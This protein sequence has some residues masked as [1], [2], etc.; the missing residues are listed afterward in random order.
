MPDEQDLVG[1]RCACTR[2]LDTARHVPGPYA[3]APVAAERD[4]GRRG[5]QAARRAEP[6]VDADDRPADQDVRGDGQAVALAVPPRD[7]GVLEELALEAGHAERALDHPEGGR[8][9]VDEQRVD[10]RATRSHRS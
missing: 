4:Q 2:D 5:A 9:A 6:A 3:L 8:S 10:S 1:P 7:L